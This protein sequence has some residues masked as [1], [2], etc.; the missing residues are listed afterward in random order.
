M[1]VERYRDVADMP[2]PPRGDPRDPGTFARVRDLWRF[3]SRLPP[4]FAPGLYRYRS[5]EESDRARE[6]A[7]IARMRS[8]R[9]RSRPIGL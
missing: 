1:P 5:V 3:S 7:L 4:L 9:R 2:S 6:Q 8:L